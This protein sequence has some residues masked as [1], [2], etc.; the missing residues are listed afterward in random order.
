MGFKELK[1]GIKRKHIT[2]TIINKLKVI[3]QLEK[4][5]LS[6]LLFTAMFCFANLDYHDDLSPQL[7]W[8]N[9]VLL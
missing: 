5:V 8:I 1:S 9:G 6:F 4:G 3:E 7:I 2:L